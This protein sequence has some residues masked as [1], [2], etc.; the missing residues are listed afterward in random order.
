MDLTVTPSGGT[1][2]K[3]S[4]SGSYLG[5][6]NKA[7]TTFTPT[8]AGNYTLTCTVTN[9]YGCESTCSV[10]ICVMD[11]RSGGSGNNQRVYLCHVPSND[12]NNP[13]TLDINT[14]LVAAHLTGHAGD[15]LGSC[16]QSCGM[17]KQQGSDGEIYSMGDGDL[18]VYPNPSNSTFNFRLESGSNELVSITIY[19]INGRMIIEKSNLNPNELVVIGEEL[20]NGIYSAV[21]VQGELRKTVK[22]SK[23]K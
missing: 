23:I 2:F 12:P 5:S 1:S 16:S 21:V 13:Q 6:T 9:N 18:I 17:G 10:V 3:Y 19:D 7:N 11:I 8:A 22:I 14:N 4:W 20:A 15:R